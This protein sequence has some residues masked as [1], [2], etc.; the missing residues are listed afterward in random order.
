MVREY[1][2]A[3]L[4]RHL[5]SELHGEALPSKPSCRYTMLQGAV[6]MLS[7]KDSDATPNNRHST[8]S[9]AR[10]GVMQPYECHV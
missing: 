3:C 8:A 4:K 5:G 10:N 1:R 6:T 7:V 2:I 9:E